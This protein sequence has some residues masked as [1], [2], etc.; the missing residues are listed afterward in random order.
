MDTEELRDIVERAQ[1]G[2]K[3]AFGELYDMHANKI[4]RFISFKIPTR[5]QAEDIL[6]ET[7]FKAWQA[8]PKLKLEDLNFSAWLYRIARNL[9]NDFY[10]VA[11]RR[12]TPDNLDD[13]YD[14]ASSTD[15]LEEVSTEFD[16]NV[17][18]EAVKRLSAHYR[19][20]LELRFI[21]E[22]SIEE[23]ANIMGKTAIAVRI[24]QH[25]AI[26]KL[27]LLL[28]EDHESAQI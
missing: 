11:K 12:P 23:T 4:Y 26:K 14:L 13:Y 25:R 15:T 7:F 20:V 1:K 21:Q 3:T 28:T 10:R 22:L 2:E 24:T 9:V 16:I 17:M 8:L 27:N 5:E 19:Q 6:Q 18:R